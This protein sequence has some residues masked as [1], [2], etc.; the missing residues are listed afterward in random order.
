MT[1]DEFYF[2]VWNEMLE[3]NLADTITG[4]ILQFIYDLF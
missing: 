4:R 3:S 2:H 1:V